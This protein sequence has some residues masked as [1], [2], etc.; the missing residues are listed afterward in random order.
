MKCLIFYYNLRNNIC[1]SPLFNIV[2]IYQQSNVRVLRSNNDNLIL[3]EPFSNTFS[4]EKSLRYY[5]PRL[6]NS[7]PTDNFMK[8]NL[9]L[10][11]YLR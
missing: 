6:I 2:T 1:P 4:A 7:F 8:L 5:L 11:K 10:N 9:N 3:S